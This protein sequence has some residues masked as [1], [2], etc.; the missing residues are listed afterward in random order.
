MLEVSMSEKVPIMTMPL[1]GLNRRNS[2]QK[3]LTEVWTRLVI[4]GRNEDRK[5]RKK[6]FLFGSSSP[7]T[8]LNIPQ[9]LSQFI[10]NPNSKEDTIRVRNKSWVVQS[11]SATIK[12]RLRNK[13][14]FNFC[15]FKY[16]S[17]IQICTQ[18][19]QFL[20]LFWLD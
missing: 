7:I 15:L 20:L 4:G 13:F 17:F 1:R 10:T 9:I 5:S 19:C 2:K 11:I 8:M 16:Y 14:F 6:N 18:F 3:Y 12:S